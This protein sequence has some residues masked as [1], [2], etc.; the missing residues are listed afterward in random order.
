MGTVLMLNLDLSLVAPGPQLPIPVFVIFIK[1]LNFSEDFRVNL[2]NSNA[3]QFS[4]KVRDVTANGR[5]C[6]HWNTQGNSWNFEIVSIATK[7][8]ETSQI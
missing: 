1:I 8:L 5:K 2:F 6:L 4:G 7:N 3:F